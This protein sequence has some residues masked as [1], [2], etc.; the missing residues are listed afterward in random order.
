MTP[1]RAG[2]DAEAVL[3]DYAEQVVRQTELLREA[4]RGGDVRARVPSCPEWNLGQLVRHV[5]GTHRWAAESVRARGA[6][7]SD[8]LVEDVGTGVDEDLAALDGWLAEGAARLADALREA[9]PD[10]PAWTPAEGESTARFWGRRMTFETVLHRCDAALATGRPFAVEA[11]VAADGLDEW[12]TFA[13]VSEAYQPR[14][15][16]PPLLG[17]G[18]ALLFQA[19]DVDRTWRVDLTGDRPTWTRASDP[20][21]V[22]VRGPL[23]E[24]LLTVYRRP[25]PTTE[26]T[27]DA[28]LLDLWLTRT[29]FWLEAEDES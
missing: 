24:L 13:G 21:A 11:A 15:D 12:M 20:A 2:C 5:G 10:A 27:G 9:G 7:V 18:R 25:T 29:G 6:E 19:T 26:T 28:A 17:P 3:D 16:L 4:V 22:T 23:T 14:P 1:A 8:D